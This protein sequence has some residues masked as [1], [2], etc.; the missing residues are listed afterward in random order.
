VEGVDEIPCAAEC[1]RRARTHLKNGDVGE[2]SRWACAVVDAGDHFTSWQA[3]SGILRK[4]GANFCRRTKVALLGSYTTAQFGPLLQLACGRL[5][6]SAEVYEA[7]YGQYRQ[8][9]LD[10]SSGLFSS[11][12]TSS[13]S[14]F[15]RATS[16]SPAT[17]RTPDEDVDRELARWTGLWGAITDRSDA[18]VIQPTFVQPARAPMG[19]LGAKLRGLALPDAAVAQRRPGDA[20]GDRV[21]LV[22]AERLASAI[23]RD[24]WFDPRYWHIAKQAVALTALPLLAR[25]TASVIA[26]SMGLTRKCLVLDLDNTLWGG[27]VVKTDSMGSG[28]ATAP[29]ERRSAHS[30]ST[31]SR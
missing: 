24:E 26:A 5:G 30:R 21:L 11:P 15:T 16:G 7:Q 22:D 1:L 9:V 27:V 12:P 18:R 29:R 20:A 25:H 10:L 2:A 6:I 19:H 13:S 4:S 3:A 14:P 28:S 17:A 8:E 23:G 31:S